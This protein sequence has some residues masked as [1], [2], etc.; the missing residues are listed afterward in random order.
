MS[1][2]QKIAL[3]TYLFLLLV[4]VGLMI[5]ADFLGPTA[6]AS[7]LPAATEGFKIVLAAFVGAISAILGNGKSVT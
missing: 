5:G 4:C 7:V 1:Y 6:R 3:L 2:G